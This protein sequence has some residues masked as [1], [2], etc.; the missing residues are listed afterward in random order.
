MKNKITCPRCGQTLPLR[1]LAF[2]FLRMECPHCHSLYRLSLTWPVCLLIAILTVSLAGLHFF[3]G[4][5]V[6]LFVIFILIYLFLPFWVNNDLIRIQ[7][8]KRQK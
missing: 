2:L 7:M 3:I 6:Y 4:L 5:I 1:P 8:R